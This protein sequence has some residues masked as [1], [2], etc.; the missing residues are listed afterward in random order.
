[1]NNRLSELLRQQREQSQNERV[2]NFLKKRII[3]AAEQF[4]VQK[5]A[6]EVKKGTNP[7]E[8]E[9]LIENQLV[10]SGPSD[11]IDF[12]RPHDLFSSCADE[13][14]RGTAFEEEIVKDL[15][16]DLLSLVGRMKGYASSYR[17]QLQS[18]NQVELLSNRC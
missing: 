7:P 18:D 15:E 2:S 13:S 17:D 10:S 4:E 6:K 1:M 11:T 3:K 16:E 12:G 5:A 8:A 14:K 9:K